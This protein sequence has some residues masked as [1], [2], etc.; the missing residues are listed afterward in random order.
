M[1]VPSYIP[2]LNNKIRQIG[3]TLD[4]VVSDHAPGTWKDLRGHDGTQIVYAGGSEK[5]IYGDPVVN[6]IFRAWH[7]RLH[8]RYNLDFSLE[9]EIIIAVVQAS[10]FDGICADLVYH[11]V[12]SQ[13]IEYNKTG[14]FPADQTQFTWNQL[15]N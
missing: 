15:N 13:A 11:E 1:N 9:S 10:H 14:I 7:D 2:S 8:L 3:K 4:F 12:A 6:Y 5:T